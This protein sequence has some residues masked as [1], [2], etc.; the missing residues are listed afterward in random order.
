MLTHSDIW[1]AID[2]L[3][4]EHG[5]S[6]SGLARRS[7]LDPTTFNK[8]KRTSRD[9]KL[10]WPST[11][12]I[13][14]ILTATGAELGQFVSYAGSAPPGGTVPTIPFLGLAEAAEDRHFT[15]QGRP[16]GG[17]WDE[18]PFPDPDD[19]GAFALEIAGH[20]FAPVYRDGDIIVLSPEAEIRRGDR[21]VLCTRSTSDAPQDGT[22]TGDTIIGVLRRRSVHTIDLTPLD[23]LDGERSFSVAEVAW[24]ARIVWSSQ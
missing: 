24:M 15:D 4:Q 5:L 11:E 22:A 16:R 7:G 18:I 23:A 1:R 20:G 6:P 19:T 10:R 2:R 3:A 12:S 13:A 17:A 8:S 21:V 9:G 14:K